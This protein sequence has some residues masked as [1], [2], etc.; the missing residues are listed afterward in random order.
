DKRPTGNSKTK[1]LAIYNDLIYYTA[2]EGVL[3]ALD[4]RDGKVRWEQKIGEA[5]HTSGPL[6]VEGKVISGRACART[7]ESCF[8]AANDALTGKDVW[9]FQDI[10][11]PGEPGSETWGPGGPADG[12][13]ASTWALMG[14]YD[15]ARKTILWGIANPMPN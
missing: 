1:G 6:V 9:K 13:M 2:P 12:M 10:P 4:A 3:V 8:I 14:S 11:A 5:Q 15:V 7:R